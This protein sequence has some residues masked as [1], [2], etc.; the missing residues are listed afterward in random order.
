MITLITENIAKNN[1]KKP[2]RTYIYIYDTCKQ[3]YVRMQLIKEKKKVPDQLSTAY[4]LEKK[5][6]QLY[7]IFILRDRVCVAYQVWFVSSI[8]AE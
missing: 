1:C 2:M 4:I 7:M 3:V 8:N 6:F 5:S